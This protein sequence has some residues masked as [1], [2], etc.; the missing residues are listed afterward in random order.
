M[1]G[2]LDDRGRL[3]VTE[4]SGGDLYAELERKAK[5]CRISRLVDTNADD[6][7][8]TATVFIDGLSPSMGLVWREHKLYAADPPDLIVFEGHR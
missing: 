5:T 1:F 3:F 6:Q 8:D 4:S 2:T 7:Y